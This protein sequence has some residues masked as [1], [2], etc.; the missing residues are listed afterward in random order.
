MVHIGSERFPV[1]AV[2]R[3]IRIIGSFRR[4]IPEPF[5][6]CADLRALNGAMIYPEKTPGE[7]ATSLAKG[8]NSGYL[9]MARTQLANRRAITEDVMS[10]QR[11]FSP[12]Y[13]VEDPAHDVPDCSIGISARFKRTIATP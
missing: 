10:G 9:S 11:A 6:V 4:P 13:F 7:K 12:E 5:V 1:A 3:G 2:E 8:G